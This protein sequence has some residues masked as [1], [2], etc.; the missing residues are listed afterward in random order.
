MHLQ[1][2]HYR[3]LIHR[4]YVHELLSVCCIIAD[5]DLLGHTDSDD[6]TTEF[7]E[8]GVC[9][10]LS[11][12]SDLGTQAPAQPRLKSYPMTQFG[13]KKTN[14]SFQPTWYV[15]R[16]WLEYSVA[17]DR[18]YCYPCR[19]FSSV[20]KCKDHTF[21]VTGFNCWKTATEKNKG[22]QKHAV[23][24]M[25][26]NAMAQWCERE[27]RKS[28]KLEV[29]EIL[30]QG[31]IDK[32]R[33]YVTSI[34]D[35][36]QFLVMNEMSFRGDK[37]SA[38][39]IGDPTDRLS[40]GK[41]LNLFAYTIK[42]DEKLRLIIPTIPEN[43]KYTSPE[44]QNEIVETMADMVLK[45]IVADIK[46]S[47]AGCFTI[48]C[49]GT[50]DKNNV[51][52]MSLAVRYVKD[53]VAKERLLEMTQLHK[54]DAEYIA[55]TIVQ[56]LDDIGLD[57]STVL[58]QCYDGASVMSG[59][60]GGVQV[61]LQEHIGKVIPYVHCF[62]HQLH[63][64]II[65]ALEVDPEI[66]QFFDMC[67]AL[68]KFT[69]RPNVSEIYDGTKLKRLLDQRW[70]GHLATVQVIINSFSEIQ[71]MLEFC[72]KSSVLAGDVVALAIGFIAQTKAP[73]FLIIARM[74]LTLLSTLNPANILL[75][76]DCIDLIDGITL[77]ES[78]AQQLRDMR[79]E[80]SEAFNEIWEKS[81]VK[82][83]SAVPAAMNNSSVSNENVSS[84]EFPP[85]SKRLCKAN[86]RYLDSVVMTTVGQN[87]ERNP[88]QAEEGQQL[89]TET[90]LL[91]I[92]MKRLFYSVLDTALTEIGCRFGERSQ[93]YVRALV[94]LLPGS[95]DFLD[96]SVLKPLVDLIG[97]NE[98]QLQCEIKV[99]K[100]LIELRTTDTVASA[101][102][103]STPTFFKL[104]GAMKVLY[105]FR[106]GF[107]I[108]YKLFA[109]ASTFGTSTAVCENSFSCLTRMLT[110]YRRSMLQRRLSNL[111][112]LSFE[113]DLTENLD[114]E[115]FLEIFRSK[116]RRLKL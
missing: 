101:S 111:V 27:T 74:M 116:C 18:C 109:S 64:V 51:E 49:D 45:Q 76:S 98:T 59:R 84:T 113:K 77:V 23:S 22:L 37:E 104:N 110:P 114:R 105:P 40:Q 87:A 11:I 62:N 112:L 92:D 99:A 41:F 33:Y 70:T 86:S 88:P 43:A 19:V 25:H 32:N 7:A 2:L 58:S 14:R 29:S 83:D 16:K 42:K 73:K 48:K 57:K 10:D 15:G 54:F 12:P 81:C 78:C 65:H 52:N 97:L 96:I 75:Q 17:H 90:E 66:R 5:H 34:F 28:S 1:S 61:K 9:F 38:A 39:E 24:Q 4:I 102:S 69:R 72:S 56:R 53:A 20:D 107:P 89:P 50:R 94:G 82:S 35:V 95:S 63:L 106:E 60:V 108:L 31:Q 13:R 8:D 67:D 21:T 71:E 100:P 46:A 115:Q 85:R 26:I 36:V 103:C 6:D 91:A 30:C 80:D 3:C 44:I 68:Y 55:K 79:K 93:P 47:D